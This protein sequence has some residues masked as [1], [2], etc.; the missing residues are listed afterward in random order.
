MIEQ[1][2]VQ[3]QFQRWLT[4]LLGYDFEILYQPGLLKKAA[5][6]LS[7]MNPTVE[8]NT[9]ISPGL[10]DVETVMEEVKS[11][12]ELQGIIVVLKENP[13]GKANYQWVSDNL[14]YKGRLV[15]SKTSSLIPALLHTFHDSV[16]WGH[17]GFLR[18]YKRMNGEIHWVGMKNDVK[19]Y[20]EQCETCQR[21]KTEALSPAGLLQP[22]PLP[23]LILEDWTM[24]FI[25][26]LPK[27]GGFDSIMV[28]VGRLSKMAHFITLKHP[29][30]AKQVAEKFSKEIIS[31]HGIPNSIVT[32]RD[33]VFLSH[34]WK[35]LFTAM[36]ASLKRST[37]FHPQT[38]GQTERANRCL[39]TYLCCFCNEQP[40]KWHKCIP[41]AELWYNTT[42]H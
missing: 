29:F 17:S 5:D 3:P 37:A 10:L 33:K 26:G 4:K 31:K 42:F 7:R 18:T 22:L 35:E 28:V 21:N 40:T 13:E 6:A 2:E 38:D 14:L 20:V 25:E 9:L 19:K 34:F 27:A 1:R 11:D 36:G 30:T 12:E 24:D 39:E 15:L 41:W 8:L 16:L 23:N 32:D